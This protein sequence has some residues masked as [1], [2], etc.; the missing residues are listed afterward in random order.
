[1]V[2][3]CL[4]RTLIKFNMKFQKIL[5]TGASG[6][7]GT[8]AISAL[9]ENGYTPRAMVRQD[10]ERAEHLR[11]L[12]AQ[13]VIGNYQDLLSLKVALAGVDAAIFIHPVAEGMAEAALYFSEAAKDTGLKRLVHVSLASADPANPSPHARS[14][15]AAEKIFERAG[16]NVT[17]VRFQVFFLE[18]TFLHAKEI[19]EHSTISNPFGDLKAGWLTGD[20]A[21]KA[22]VAVLLNERFLTERT[23]SVASDSLW[24]FPQFAALLTELLGRPVAYHEISSDEWAASLVSIQQQGLIPKRAVD[25]LVSQ[26]K[27][28]KLIKQMPPAILYQELVSVKPAAAQVFFEN[29]LDKFSG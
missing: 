6:R 23:V 15:W 18:N 27:I 4:Q 21:G 5:V 17:H 20:E 26:S 13:V 16:F 9:I 2:Y 22:A 10:D 12:G 8:G 29:N 14:Q 7:S 19:A 11:A 1:M 24:S 3:I 28:L 25:H